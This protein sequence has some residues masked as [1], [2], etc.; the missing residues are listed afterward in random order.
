MST[1]PHFYCQELCGGPEATTLQEWEET[2]KL[3]IRLGDPNPP[4]RPAACQ[5]QCDACINAVLDRQA[6]TRKLMKP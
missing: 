4:R 6:Q 2:R 3:L 5:V 1:K